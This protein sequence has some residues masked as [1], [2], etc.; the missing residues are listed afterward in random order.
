[1]QNMLASL[2][3]QPCTSFLATW[4]P[5]LPCYRNARIAEQW[6]LDKNM[7][8]GDPQKSTPGE[9]LAEEFKK[10]GFLLVMFSHGMG[11]SRTAYGSVCGEFASYGF[12]VCVMDH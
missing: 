11:G 6:P 12:I 1:M 9:Q 2:S 10:L 7:K 8:Q 3:G 4:Y 5:K